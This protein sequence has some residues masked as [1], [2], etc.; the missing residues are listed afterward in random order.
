[1]RNRLRGG[2]KRN[3][4]SIGV[5]A[6]LMV[7]ASV[8]VPRAATAQTDRAAH[9]SPSV[10]KSNVP[11]THDGH[12]DLQGVWSFASATPLERSPQ[13]ADKPVLTDAEA[14]A[15][16]K[17]LPSGGCRFV[18]CDGSDQGKLESAYDDGG[19]EA[20]AKLAENRTS[21]IVDPPNGKIPALTAEAQRRVAELRALDPSRAFLDGPEQATLSDRCIIGFN[22][23]PPMTPSAYNNNVQIF[24]LGS[25]LV[26]LNEMVHNAR[27]VA[28]D[29]RPR[30]PASMRL[31]VGDSRGRWEGDTL[32]VETTNFRRDSLVGPSGNTSIS[33]ESIR[34]IERFT[35]T[36]PD[37]LQYEYT[38]DDPRTWTRPWTVRI[39]M[40]R[41]AEHIYEY[42]CHEG[43]YSM[44]NRLSA[45]RAADG[46][47]PPQKN[48]PR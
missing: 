44:R 10:A 37:M 19:Y 38:M 6:A 14:A 7:M 31:W 45:A 24:Q 48:D 25:H 21:L 3:L 32:V 20:G 5:G 23:G 11:R 26:V 4:T 28:L 22:S 35:R 43:N 29:G 36:S 47:A 1:M 18:K 16:L 46:K 2:V 17:N 15:F 27:I 30:L 40:T 42:A 12:P 34:L 13:F 39:P 9:R 33:P 8:F 41:S